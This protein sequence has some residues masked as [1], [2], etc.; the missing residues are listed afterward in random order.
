MAW[1]FIVVRI[2]GSTLVVPPLEEVFYRSFVYRTIAASDFQKVPLGY[3]AWVP[4]LVTS[5]IFGFAHYQWLA[6]ILCGLSYQWLVIRKGR[7]G[8]AMTAHAITNFLLGVW[9]VWQGDWKFW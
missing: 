8:D 2:V 6:G 1:F 3:F 5:A 9:I 7:L 4:F